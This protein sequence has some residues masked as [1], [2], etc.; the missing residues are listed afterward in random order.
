MG[1]GMKAVALLL[2]VLLPLARGDKQNLCFDKQ[3]E[4]SNWAEM[5]ECEKNAA[6]M[7][8][9]C[10]AAC[11]LCKLP[12][13]ITEADDPLLGPERLALQTDYGEIV[14]GFYPSVAPVT[15]AHILKLARLGGYNTNRAR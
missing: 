10:P 11:K 8:D 2:V 9:A 14:L 6:F 15:V 7:K 5:G 12:P 1:W 13:T 3:N 4:C